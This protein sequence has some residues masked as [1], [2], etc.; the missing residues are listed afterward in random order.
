MLD[1]QPS[2]ATDSSFALKTERGPCTVELPKSPIGAVRTGVYMQDQLHPYWKAAIENSVPLNLCVRRECHEFVEG[3]PEA[4]VYKKTVCEDI[5]YGLAVEQ[6]F[7]VCRVGLETVEYIR[8]P[9]NHFD[10]QLKKFQTPPDQYQD[11]MPQEQRELH[12]IRLKL[13]QEKLA[14][15]QDKFRRIEKTPDLVAI[16][17]WQKL[18]IEALSQNR[19]QD[20]IVLFEQGISLEPNLQET[21]KDP[22]AVAYNNLGSA[23]R[24][25]GNHDQAIGFFDK[26]LQLNP[27]LPRADL[28]RI[29]LNAATVL[30]EQ[31][32][33]E[34]ALPYL[35]KTLELEPASSE[36]IAE[37]NHV[38]YQAQ[39]YTKGYQFSS[40]QFNG[41]VGIWKQCLDKVANMPALNALNINSG[42]GQ[43][44]CWLIDNILTH[45]SSTVTCVDVF[46]NQVENSSGDPNETFEELNYQFES[47]IVKTG[48][49]ERITKRK[50]TPQH[51][52]RSLPLNSFHLVTMGG[53]KPASDVLEAA[54]LAWDYSK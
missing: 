49:S 48:H 36:A 12:T 11:D 6:F 7:K 35:Q 4:P 15:L 37:F 21:V 5:A 32:A 47:N 54:L 34:R 27:S 14:Y 3:F 2:T 43:L 20:A 38:Q 10:R 46:K 33:F 45:D 29:Y 41:Q 39:I 26:A 30:K 51:V 9:G 44:A 1:H 19:F 52:L 42:D 28:A 31:G 50:G 17:N 23:L 18:A 25:Q 8:Y 22:L 24:K 53:P 40:N 16:L 13:E